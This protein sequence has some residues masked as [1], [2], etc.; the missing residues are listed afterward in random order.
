MHENRSGTESS[1][2]GSTAGISGAS[3]APAR[4]DRATS[5]AARAW[6][7]VGFALGLAAGL[8]LGGWVALFASTRGT[9]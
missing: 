5:C 3:H 6:A 4:G 1:E 8:A 7:R 2:A 9:P